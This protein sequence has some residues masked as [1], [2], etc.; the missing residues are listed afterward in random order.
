M[1]KLKL[2]IVRRDRTSGC[3][4]FMFFI[5]GLHFQKLLDIGN[6]TLDLKYLGIAALSKDRTISSENIYYPPNNEHLD[7]NMMECLF[8]D[9]SSIL[10]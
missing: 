8:E 7:T 10:G 6:E 1:W 2:N 9:N 4:G 5:R 3:G